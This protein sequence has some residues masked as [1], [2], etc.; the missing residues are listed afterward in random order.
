MEKTTN[1]EPSDDRLEVVT[2]AAIR[3][4]Y[5][6]KRKGMNHFLALQEPKEDGISGE[7]A[8]RIFAIVV[9]IIP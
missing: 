4:R 7:N 5:D 9:K 6:G 8:H 1:I 2:E 3:K